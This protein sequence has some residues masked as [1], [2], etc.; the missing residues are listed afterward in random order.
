MYDC[1]FRYEKMIKEEIVQIPS[2][3]N[4]GKLE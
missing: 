2:L 3:G 1:L 4:E